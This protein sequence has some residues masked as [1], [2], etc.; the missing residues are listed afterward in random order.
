[1]LAALM[2]R[3][4]CEKGSPRSKIWYR[5]F[6]SEAVQAEVQEPHRKTVTVS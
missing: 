1:M 2:E 3:V 5:T 4:D 6:I